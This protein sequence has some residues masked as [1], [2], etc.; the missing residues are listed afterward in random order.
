MT[1]GPHLR[2]SRVDQPLSG[3]GK[4]PLRDSVHRIIWEALVQLISQIPLSLQ[5]RGFPEQVKLRTQTLRKS[6]VQLEI[7]RSL[8]GAAAGGSLRNEA[9]GLSSTVR[10]LMT[11]K[12]PNQKTCF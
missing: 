12:E 6:P 3:T 10:A 8:A 11:T 7:N 2:R 5:G 9:F 1:P 4:S